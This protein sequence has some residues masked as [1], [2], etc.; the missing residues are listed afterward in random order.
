MNRPPV[1]NPIANRTDA[2]G[3]TVSL[4]PSASDPD[5]DGLGWTAIGLPP[6]LI[7]DPGSGA[8]T[9]T[10][11]HSAAAS[12]PYAVTI[13]ATD[14]GTPALYDEESFTWTVTNTNRPPALA[15]PGD[16]TS[17]EGDAISIT[18]SAPDPDGDAVTFQAFGLP[19][20][21]TIGSSTGTISGTIGY[22]A[23]DSSPFSVLVRAFDD[24]SP[25]E[26]SEATITW[27]VTDTNRPPVVTAPSD[28]TDA[29]AAT[30]GLAVSGTDPD[31]DGLTWSAT[32]LPSGLS[33]DPDTGFISG[34]ISY[35]A[36]GIH[37]V[38]VRATDDGAPSEFHE[39]AF[40]WTVTNTNRPPSVV[41]PGD[42]SNGENDTVA[43]AMAGSDPD[44]DGLSWSASGLPGGLA[45]DPGSGVVSG[46]IDF[47][48]AAGSPYNVTVRAT[49]DDP[50]A[51]F[52][53]VTFA[54]SVTDTNRPPI[55]TSPGDLAHAE[56]DPVAFA[57]PGSDPDGDGLTWSATGLPQGLAIDPA[58]GTISGVIGFD[59]AA[60]SPHAVTVRATD[61]GTPS[62]FDEVA[63]TWTVTDTNRAPVVVSPEISL[64]PRRTPSRSRSSGRTRTATISPGRPPACRAVSR[65][66]PSPE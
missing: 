64:M 31:G 1:L 19:P 5:G 18:V 49:D 9:G 52:D 30:I 62:E 51:M 15:T 40:T 66:R 54:W 25:V 44:G 13:R 14:N 20:G 48:S 34:T 36:E 11:D 53:E 17:N 3:I 22:T 4:S 38:F 35:A 63:F 61:D 47:D 39:V 56:G 24:G 27:T 12:S 2:E 28:R 58:S 50:A 23:S 42:Q 45:I 55:V 8:I 16:Q 46:T 59:A 21:L 29:E 65:S 37:P 43:L 7:I 10:I 6:G 33:I 26:Q 57:I 32:G 41:D 60:P